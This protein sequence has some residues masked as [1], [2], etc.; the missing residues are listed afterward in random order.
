LG[1]VTVV[2]A[3]CTYL[4]KR[5]CLEAYF[6]AWLAS[7][8]GSLFQTAAAYF[9]QLEDKV[10]FRQLEYGLGGRKTMTNKKSRCI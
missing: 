3:D 10:Y 2:A 1:V 5:P 7:M 4:D 6:Q 9:R 8:L